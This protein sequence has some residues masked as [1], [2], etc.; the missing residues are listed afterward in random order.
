ML[1]FKQNTSKVVAGRANEALIPL[2]NMSTSVKIYINSCFELLLWEALDYNLKEEYQTKVDPYP[3]H[4]GEQYQV[5]QWSRSSIPSVT[6]IQ[7]FTVQYLI[8]N[9]V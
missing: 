4:N 9:Y 8:E 7:G 2:I 1:E 6:Y 3:Q 5:P